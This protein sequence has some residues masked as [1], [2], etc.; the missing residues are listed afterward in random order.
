MNKLA[1]LVDNVLPVPEERGFRF[2]KEYVNQVRT[3]LPLELSGKYPMPP[4]KED[5]VSE[6]DRLWNPPGSATAPS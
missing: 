6:A 5:V 3:V 4:T 1:L 2:Q